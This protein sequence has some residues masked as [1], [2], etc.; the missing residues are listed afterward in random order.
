[1]GEVFFVADSSEGVVEP[2][3]LIFLV[4][5]PALHEFFGGPGLD[6]RAAPLIS[7]ADGQHQCDDG[8]ADGRVAQQQHEAMLT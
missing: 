5:V 7:S 1:V 6:G 4:R 2:E 8:L 3:E